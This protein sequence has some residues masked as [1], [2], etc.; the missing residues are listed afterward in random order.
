M[1]VGLTPVLDTIGD[2]SAPPEGFV[3]AEE[4]FI[5]RCSKALADLKRFAREVAEC[6]A[7]QVAAVTQSHYPFIELQR[8]EVRFSEEVQT[9]AQADERREAMRNTAAVMD[10]ALEFVEEAEDGQNA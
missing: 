6:T 1:G 4:R 8:L 5:T 9:L 10:D 3:P 7:R 2:E